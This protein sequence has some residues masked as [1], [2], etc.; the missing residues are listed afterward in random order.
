MEF[1]G[2]NEVDD[3]SCDSYASD[4]ISESDFDFEYDGLADNLDELHLKITILFKR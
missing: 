3:E 1:Y 4:D 2:N